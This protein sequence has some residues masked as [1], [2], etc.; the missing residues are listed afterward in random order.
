VIFPVA[1]VF[2]SCSTENRGAADD[3]LFN[4]DSLIQAQPK[5][6]ISISKTASLGDDV[7]NGTAEI[8]SDWK[9]ELAAF[10]RI[11]IMNLP[12]WQNSYLTASGPDPTSNLMLKKIYATDSA[13]PVRELR[14]AFFPERRQIIRL[15]A[16]LS[17]SGMFYSRQENL[18]MEFDPATG[19]LERYSVSGT[20][21]LAWFEPDQYRISAFVSYPENP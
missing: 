3:L 12:V 18:N 16:K 8:S 19:R 13:A 17:E 15:E 14:L 11:G 7:G 10:T 20:Q 2:F 1:Q 9:E 21:K 4:M 6:G 5:S